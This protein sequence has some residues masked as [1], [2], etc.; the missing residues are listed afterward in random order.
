MD[1]AHFPEALL[2]FHTSSEDAQRATDLF[3]FMSSSFYDILSLLYL[4]T[5]QYLLFLLSR[6]CGFDLYPP[7]YLMLVIKKLEVKVIFLLWSHLNVSV[8]FASPHCFLSVPL[9]P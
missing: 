8:S 3:G 5:R 1:F 9:C 7:L 6:R 4:R 2:V